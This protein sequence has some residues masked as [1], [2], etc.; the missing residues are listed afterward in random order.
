MKTF[1]RTGCALVL[2]C[3][4]SQLATAKDKTPPAAP[5]PET[6][7]SATPASTA[8]LALTPAL[9]IYDTALQSGWQNWSWAKTELSV[10]ITGSARVPIKV[11]AG[12]WQ[13]L[14]LHH[15]AFSTGNYTRLT[16]LIQGTAPDGQVRVMALV[17]GK[18]VGDGHLVKLSNSGWTRVGTPL[19]DLGVENANIDGIWVQNASANP[20][21]KFYVTE[22]KL[23]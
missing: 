1:I 15:D 8:E 20:M 12:P 17:D 7:L 6:A 14:Y 23:E 3:I 4:G 9:V 21:P 19:A 18:A 5:A 10:G 22:I 13:A 2:T 11:E 16:M